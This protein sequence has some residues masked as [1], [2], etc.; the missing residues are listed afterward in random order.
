MIK[1][2]EVQNAYLQGRHA[3]MV[4]LA[5]DQE[6]PTV[7]GIV[8]SMAGPDLSSEL[9]RQNVIRNLVGLGSQGLTRS[10]EDYSMIGDSRVHPDRLDSE[11]ISPYSPMQLA[12]MENL[13]RA[14]M[15]GGLAGGSY[16]GGVS[17]R[18]TAASGAG[19]IGG[20]MIGGNLGRA[21][22]AGIEAFNVSNP[23]DRKGLDSALAQRLVSG[24]GALGGL[25]GGL[26]AGYLS[27]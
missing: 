23:D 27:R 1:H 6:L 9:K 10:V 13:S 8:K 19:A 26:G 12:T 16:L 15:L 22:N 14:G 20:A 5:K 4:K 24:G 18:A 7:E 2:A 11:K 3:A 17:P 25:A 21:L